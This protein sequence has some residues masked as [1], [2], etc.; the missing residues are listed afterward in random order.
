[1]SLLET[2]GQKE[3]GKLIAQH[4]PR[5][6]LMALEDAYFDGDKKGRLKGRTFAHGHKRSAAG[7]IKH[8]D[9]NEN[10]YEALLAHGANPTPLRG[11]RLVIGRLGIFNIVRMNVPN[12]KWTDLHRGKTRQTLAGVNA[13][14]Q[15]KYIQGDFFTKSRNVGEATLF[16]LGVMDGQDEHGLAQLTQCMVALPA[17]DMQSWLYLKTMAEFIEVYDNKPEGSQIDNAVPK[18]KEAQP[19]KRTGTEDDNG[20]S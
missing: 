13:D 14:I 3:L 7:A 11:N 20:N 9:T 1:M 8:F 17:P 18:L 5:D 15:R 4:I 12:H 19:K 2:K 6:T 10:F 16:F